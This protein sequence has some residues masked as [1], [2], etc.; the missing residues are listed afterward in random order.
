MENGTADPSQ[1]AGEVRLI[2]FAPKVRML[3]DRSASTAHSPHPCPLRSRLPA[4]DGNSHA[5]ADTALADARSKT[6]PATEADF[7]A[8]PLRATHL[9]SPDASRAVRICTSS[10][11]I[12][13][14]AAR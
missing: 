12:P 2:E 6:A 4:V 9:V 1:C 7:T 8:K 14:S 13:F 5:A 10:V 3:L 11:F